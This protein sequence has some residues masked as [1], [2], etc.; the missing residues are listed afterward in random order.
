MAM[1]HL[2]FSFLVFL[3]LLVGAGGMTGQLIL[4]RELLVVFYG[5]ELTLGLILANWLLAEAVGAYLGGRKLLAERSLPAYYYLLLLYGLLLPPAVFLSR[6][7]SG[8]LFSPLWGEALGLGPVFLISLLVVGPISL[9]HGSLFPLATRLCDKKAAIGQIYL[10]ETLGTLLGGL[11]FSLYAAE[12]FASMEL[13]VGMAL[14]HLVAGGL[15]LAV[16]YGNRKYFAVLL[17]GAVLILFIFSPL[18]SFLE[19]KSLDI[20]WRGQERVFSGH[21]PYGHIVVQVTGEQYTFYYDGRPH[22]TV[23]APDM[24]PIQEFVHLVGA[25]HPDPQAVLFLGGGLGGVIF[26][27]LRHPVERGVYVELDPRLIQLAEKFSTPLTEK[28]L[29]DPRLEVVAADARYF[30]SRSQ[31]QFEIIFLGRISQDTLQA[32][33]L[34]TKEFFQIAGKRLTE[35][36]ILA[37][38][39]PGSSTYLS[40]EMEALNSSLYQ[41]LQEV[42]PHVLG[43]PGDQMIY[44][45][46]HSSL[47]INPSLL[48]R[49]LEERGLAGEY[50]SKAYF[51]YR[52]EE[53]RLIWL[54]E[55][56][57]GKEVSLNYDFTPAGFFHALSFW[58]RAYSPASSSV[59]AFFSDW[60]PEYFFFLLGGIFLL[61]ALFFSP[62]GTLLYAVS[63][64]GGTAMGLDLLVLFTFQ[65]LYGYIYQ[66]AGL[67]MATFM[68]GMF[69]GGRLIINREGN[70]RKTFLV[71]E[72]L[73]I[74]SLVLFYGLA[75]FL[76][77]GMDWID[78]NLTLVLL[79]I[80]ALFGGGFLG[81]QFPLAAILHPPG[82][83]GGVAGL[84]YGADLFGGYL[85]GLA[86]GFVLFPLLGLGYTLLFL[87][88][89]KATSFLLL[90]VRGR[91]L[92]NV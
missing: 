34:F 17:S 30:L 44:L 60:E 11:F 46:S 92:S 82:E 83:R 53:E 56:L 87:G 24:A 78:P 79:A 62:R 71:L 47:E 4:L 14:L 65:C 50:W 48:A 76:Q 32:N 58:G 2:N 10:Y 16:G 8:T 38:S 28:E 68:L 40:R 35:G 5:N 12:R 26:E 52:L 63:S 43:I 72:L 33:R 67:L 49:R 19:E 81:A 77:E 75:L 37:F 29:G 7:L 21:T 59:L 25:A 6:T 36:G 85:G 23:P 74:A 13:A 1:K 66:M 42:F 41:T 70:A 3:T 89:L 54:E 90:I 27:A 9:V 69:L 22:L 15:V 73:V 86:L 61:G 39:V 91:G 31:S 55:S 88:G 80:Y 64:S 57:G 84:I 18:T 51:G 20:Y 45:A